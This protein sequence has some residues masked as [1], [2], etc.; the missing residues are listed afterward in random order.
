MLCPQPWLGARVPYSLKPMHFC[1]TALSATLSAPAYQHDGARVCCFVPQN[2]GPEWYRTIGSHWLDTRAAPTA[3]WLAC[4]RGTHCRSMGLGLSS[5]LRLLPFS[6]DSP[7][8]CWESWPM[9]GWPLSPGTSAEA[10]NKGATRPV[11][12]APDCPVGVLHRR[13][14]MV[15][16][17]P[18]PW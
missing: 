8:G 10:K 9:A 14:R 18:P 7:L 3:C 4:G 12:M 5:G 13:S 6:L 1:S 17:L 15:L 11:L 16:S 2:S